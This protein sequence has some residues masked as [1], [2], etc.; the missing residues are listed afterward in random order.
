MHIKKIKK[1]MSDIHQRSKPQYSKD[2]DHVTFKDQERDVP[3]N[4]IHTKDQIRGRNIVKNKRK[5]S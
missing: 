2:K 1:I 4:Q 5:E 3:K